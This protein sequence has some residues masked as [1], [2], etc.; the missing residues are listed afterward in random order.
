MSSTSEINAGKLITAQGFDAEFY[1]ILSTDC[2]WSQRQIFE[3]LN[4]A[5]LSAFGKVRYTS[6]ESYSKVKNRRLRGR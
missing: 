1:R 6:Y 4:K 3:H 2:G 5:F